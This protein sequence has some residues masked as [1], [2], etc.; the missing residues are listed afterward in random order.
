MINKTI[1]FDNHKKKN[2]GLE[3]W[4]VDYFNESTNKLRMRYDRDT[5]PEDSIDAVLKYFGLKLSSVN[6]RK[7]VGCWYFTSK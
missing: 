2:V 1:A 4:E 7:D 3:Y 6:R 5:Y